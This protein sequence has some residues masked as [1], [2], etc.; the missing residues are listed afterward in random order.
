VHDTEIVIVG[1]GVIGAASAYELARRGARVTLLEREHP[2]FG[3]SGRNFGGLLTSGK[4]ADLALDF[5]LASRKRYDELVDEIDDFEFR[6]GGGVTYFFEEQA[7]VFPAFVERRRQLGLPIEL[8]DATAARERCPILPD[9]VAGAVFSPLEAHVHPVRVTESL[10]AAAEQHGAEVRSGT[11]V[12]GLVMTGDRCTGVRTAGG[13]IEGETVIVAA[14]TW[15][16]TLLDP[17]GVRLPIDLMR[18]HVAETEPLELRFDPT[19]FG[20][21]WLKSF[22]VASEL[23][24]YDEE[25]FTHPLEHALPGVEL[26]E[27]VAQRRDGSVLI[28]TAADFAGDDQR[29]TVHAI[30]L[31]LGVAADHLPI[32]RDLPIR[33]AWAGLLAQTPDAL[34]IMDRIPGIDGLFIATGHVFGQLMGPLSGRVIAQ[35]IFGESP[36]FDM[37]P[38]QYGRFA[39]TVR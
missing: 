14:N 32:L 39:P 6:A 21:G 31:A 2:A 38:F 23:P 27:G 34:P 9:D 12:T 1:G 5:G 35:T 18:M 3:A 33:R 15:I 8:L 37:A 30:A 22:S 29:P 36:D 20:P 26:L 13:E 17:I 10:L 7:D 24:G 28:G 16:G 25:L 19:V 4:V 11:E